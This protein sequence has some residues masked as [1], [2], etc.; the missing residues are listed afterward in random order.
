MLL[1]ELRDGDGVCLLLILSQGQCLETAEHEEAV[2]G[3]EATAFAILDEVEIVNESGV[4][5][6]DCAGH[7][8]AVAAEE[9]CC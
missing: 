4:A 9:F 8:I 7:D 5:D 3:C 6:D 1:E 2:E